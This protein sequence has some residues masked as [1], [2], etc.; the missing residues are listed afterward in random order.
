MGVLLALS[1]AFLAGAVGAVS[2]Q[3]WAIQF[4]D[5]GS[6]S[7]ASTSL[8]LVRVGTVDY[9]VISYFGAPRNL[10]Y[11]SLNP[12]TKIWNLVRV[13]AGG[14]F[15]SLDADPSGI[16]HVGY[17][18][19]STLQLKYWRLNQGQG[20]TQV[21][22]S[23]SGQGGMGYYNSLRVDGQGTPH[24]SYY[25]WR[26]PNGSTT[27]DRLKYA[28]LNGSGW[29][30]IFV[31]PA[32]GRGRYNSLALDG[33]ANPQIA[34]YDAGRRVL[35]LAKRIA[36]I[37]TNQGVDSAGNPG[38]FN[39]I[40]L[41][42]QGLPRIS[43]LAATP[44]QLRYASFDGALWTFEDVEGIGSV[45][46]FSNTS[47]ALDSNGNA[48]ISYYDA[49]SGS[50]KYASRSSGGVWTTQF[51]D[52]VGDVG[53]YSSLKLDSQN[54]PIISY[55]DATT[56]ALKIA[57]GNYPDQDLDGIPDAFDPCPTNPDCNS[58]GIVDGREGGVTAGAAGT[59]RLK[60]E[61]I[62]GCGSLAAMYGGGSPRG[63]GPPVDLLLLLAPA[64][65]L[66]RR[67]R[68]RLA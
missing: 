26:A 56:Q 61:P 7:G 20:S 41:N 19:A 65:Y 22:D 30:S 39:S 64:F 18:D 8:G 49:A 12:Q 24:V 60:D 46:S 4:V 3:T 47:L 29:A 66:L 58:N 16:V 33:S 15:T 55:F 40:A 11:A 50:L 21:I 17:L 1:L 27:A 52:S 38:W 13:D 14:E 10:K 5:V 43:Y 44:N 28:D 68:S 34:Y 32:V 53:G 36:N 67:R 45:V 2:A 57:Y 48:H 31:D 63:G 42:A 59:N 62:F 25:Y 23:E 6:T 54:R 9:P 35:R 51:V 37:W